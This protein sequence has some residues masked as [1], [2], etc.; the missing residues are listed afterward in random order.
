MRVAFVVN[1]VEAAPAVVVAGL[2]FF[3]SLFIGWLVWRCRVHR[4]RAKRIKENTCWEEVERRNM[5][6]YYALE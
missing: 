5:P 4:S 3:G 1:L 6:N 2:P